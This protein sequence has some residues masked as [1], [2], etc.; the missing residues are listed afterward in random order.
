MLCNSGT[1]PLE[2]C[3]L[4]FP[5]A[6]RFSFRGLHMK[7]FN[8]SQPPST[9][10]RRMGGW[11]FKRS[12]NLSQE[13][14]GR[15]PLTNTRN[16]NGVNVLELGCNSFM[17]CKTNFKTPSNGELMMFCVGVCI[18]PS[19]SAGK[20]STVP[21]LMPCNKM[22]FDSVLVHDALTNPNNMCASYFEGCPYNDPTMFTVTKSKHEPQFRN[23]TDGNF[24]GATNPKEM[25]KASSMNEMF[26][27]RNTLSSTNN[28]MPCGIGELIIVP[29][30]D[31]RIRQI[32]E[33]CLAW[34]WGLQAN[35]PET[36]PYKKSFP[37]RNI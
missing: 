9:S 22:N 34:K 28:T 12:R 14:S 5:E 2:S 7:H 32:I 29:F 13:N 25:W 30:Q 27:G 11:N 4:P 1:C 36:H 21:S 33:G 6:R 17:E 37:A 31:Y 15:R 20:G 10:L 18:G 8:R 23:F 3:L 35:L 19:G 24:K 26:I 16:I